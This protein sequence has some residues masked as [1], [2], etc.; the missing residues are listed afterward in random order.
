MAFKQLLK[1]HGVTQQELAHTLGIGQTAISKWC[2]GEC[3]PTAN[4]ILPIARA[5]GCTCYE[6]VECFTK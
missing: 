2:T 4:K 3:M 5:I 6:V 1:R